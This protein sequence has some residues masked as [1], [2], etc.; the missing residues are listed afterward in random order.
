MAVITRPDLMPLIIE[1]LD[2]HGF[3]GEGDIEEISLQL[4]LPASRVYGFCDQFGD[5]PRRP[6]EIRLSVCAGPS[7][8]AAGALELYDALREGAP[9]AVEISACAGE[10]RWH[11]SVAVRVTNGEGV[12]MVDGLNPADA[13]RLL[14]MIEGKDLSAYPPLEEVMPQPVEVPGDGNDSSSAGAGE[15]MP[16]GWWSADALREAAGPAGREIREFLEG[17]LHPCAHAEGR[18][19]LLVCD[20]LGAETE[21]SADLAATL[22]FAEE[23]VA[24]AAMAAAAYGAGRLVFYAPWNDGASCAR[25][26]AVASRMLDGAG[27]AHSLFRGPIRVAACPGTGRAAVVEGTMLWEAAAAGTEAGAGRP[28]ALVIPAGLARRVARNSPTARQAGDGKRT[29]ALV[30]AQ[31]RGKPCLLL[32]ARGEMS[33]AD[34]ASYVGAS[35]GCKAA[36]LAGDRNRVLPADL[37]SREGLEGSGKVVFLEEGTCMPRMAALLASHAIGGCCGGCAPGRTAPAAVSRLIK[38]IAEGR[39]GETAVASLERIV[40]LAGELALCE[41][42]G[43]ALEPVRDC[44]AG[45]AAE[46]LSHARGEACPPD[47]GRASATDGT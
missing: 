12:R 14:E 21:H 44:L 25:L 45:F 13:D 19:R 26:G 37:F 16:E 17:S 31:V 8:L 20:T 35:S 24:G 4:R 32:E 30:G 1:A 22:L 11:E 2:G 15:K 29:G 33:V 39:G 6:A 46:F 42:L 43:R 28:W 40:K 18:P 38:E 5:L 3:I 10:P 9:A 36:Y 41:K 47:H 34:I 7:C 27:M 23:V